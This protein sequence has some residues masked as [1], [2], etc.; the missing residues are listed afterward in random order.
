MVINF[1]ILCI[2]GTVRGQ[3]KK[4]NVSIPWKTGKSTIITHGPIRV[5]NKSAFQ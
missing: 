1:D 2:T 4:N 3:E 5:K